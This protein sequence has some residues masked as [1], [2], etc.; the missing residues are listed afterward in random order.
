MNYRRLDLNGKVFGHLTVLESGNS[1]RD[2]T[3]GRPRTTWVCRCEC[4]KE[5]VVVTEKLQ[6]GEVISC[7]DVGC[8]FHRP[9]RHKDLTESSFN[10]LLSNYRHNA[11]T[12]KREFSLT[13][14]EFRRITSGNC[15][16][17]GEP[18]SMAWRISNLVHTKTEPY[19]F[20]GVNRVENTKGYVSENCVSC[21][22]LCNQMKKMLS[23]ETFIRHAKK[24]S[25]YLERKNSHDC[26][27][28]GPRHELAAG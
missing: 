13:Q 21:C 9:L 7:C 11:R 1:V 20:N 6:M 8:Q 25:S 24:I 17:C 2:T 26:G 22:K 27:H 23:V 4:G 15:T 19:I 10:G 18:P 5:K 12:R 28:V 16:Y 3:T 14:E